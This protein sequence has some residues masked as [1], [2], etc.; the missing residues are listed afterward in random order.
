MGKRSAAATFAI[1]DLLPPS[2]LHHPKTLDW[3]QES[4]R[5]FGPIKRFQNRRWISSVPLT[6]GMH[7]LDPDEF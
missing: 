5:L 7:V 4:I 2:I 6:T 1:A 3:Q